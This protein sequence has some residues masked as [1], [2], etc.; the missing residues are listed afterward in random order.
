MAK[1]LTTNGKTVTQTINKFNELETDSRTF[2]EV[3]FFSGIVDESFCQQIKKFSYESL[4]ECLI[5]GFKI[6]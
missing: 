6:L 1:E 3:R 4:G 5:S 2:K